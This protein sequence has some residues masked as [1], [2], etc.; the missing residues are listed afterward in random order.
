MNLSGKKKRLWYDC[1][2]AERQHSFL[3]VNERMWHRLLFVCYFQGASVFAQWFQLPPTSPRSGRAFA[4]SYRWIHELKPRR[5]SPEYLCVQVFRRRLVYCGVDSTYCV[6]GWGNILMH[7]TFDRCQG[8]WKTCTVCE[9]T[10]RKDSY[11]ANTSSSFWIQD[12]ALS[13]STC[14]TE[15]PFNFSPCWSDYSNGHLWDAVI[16]LLVVVLPVATRVPI[17]TP[18]NPPPHPTPLSLPALVGQ[19]P[20]GTLC[21]NPY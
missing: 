2:C 19:H 12:V 20:T 14:L 3:S 10:R 7:R 9:T 15:R 5:S 18:S 13:L 11:L 6:L 1:T 21:S 17:T 4:S 8:V 16:R